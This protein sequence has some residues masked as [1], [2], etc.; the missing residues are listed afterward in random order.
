M[1]LVHDPASTHTPERKYM[2]GLVGACGS[3]PVCGS[4][5]GCGNG[6]VG[7][8]RN[9]NGCACGCGNGNRCMGGCG[10]MGVGAGVRAGMGACHG[11]R[12]A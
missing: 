2:C 5:L 9:G 1:L 3:R 8:C 6:W 11:H 10:V 7:G 4:R 12:L